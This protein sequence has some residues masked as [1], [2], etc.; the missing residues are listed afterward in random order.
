MTDERPISELYAVIAEWAIG[1]GADRLD[2]LP[3]LWN[4]ETDKWR[5][6]INGHDK[7]VDG[8]GFAHMRL[9]HK[10][11]F[12]IAVLSPFDGQIG[13]GAHEDDMIEHFRT[14]SRAYLENN[15]G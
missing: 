2:E 5:V 9:Q 14:A 4:G 8:L 6:D 11:Y 15:N 1:L 10:K 7:E 3:G 13:G 12:Q